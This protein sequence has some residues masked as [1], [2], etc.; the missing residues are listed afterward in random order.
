[1]DLLFCVSLEQM[2]VLSLGMLQFRG[3]AKVHHIHHFQSRCFAHTV[4][5][6]RHLRVSRSGCITTR[7]ASVIPPAKWCCHCQ[8]CVLFL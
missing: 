3:M 6:L 7:P 4:S 5:V 8:V 2:L 1:M